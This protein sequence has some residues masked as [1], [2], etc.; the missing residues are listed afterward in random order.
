[1]TKNLKIV[2]MGTPDFAV[3]CLQALVDHHYSISL[4]V[5]RPDQPKGRGKKIL[6]PPIKTAA[7]ALQLP[8]LQTASVK[9]E[10]FVRLIKNLGPDV[11]VVVA[12]GHILPK[13]VLE[14]PILGAI[15]VHASLLPKYRGPAPIQWAI[16]NGETITGVTTML[17][18]A[19]MDTGEILLSTSIEIH[20]ED[21]AGTLHDRLAPLGASLL[22]ETLARL[23]TQTL[24]PLPQN[25]A[26][27][28]YAPLFKKQ[29]GHI[30]WHKPADQIERWIRGL[31]PWPGAFTFINGK[32]M[33]IFKARLWDT[34]FQDIPGKVIAAS[35]HHLCVATGC[36]AL[37]VLEVQMDSGKRLAVGE[38]LKGAD[39][40]SGTILT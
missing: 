13:K 35:S 21:T 39:I 20:P 7:E 30:D 34:E 6:P 28:S 36:G 10:E 27:S 12:F 24:R 5:T 17:M 29:D 32:R 4:V 8:V 38:F 33:R 19:G 26:Q 14:I 18:D 16:I 23:E 31:T 11:M 9:S 22:I 15:N 40:P 1:M 25:H 3:P 2:F 37:S